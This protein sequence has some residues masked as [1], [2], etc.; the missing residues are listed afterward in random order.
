MLKR[1]QHDWEALLY[2]C[3]YSPADI[4]VVPF[5][6][7]AEFISASNNTVNKCSCISKM[8]RYYINPNLKSLIGYPK[9][10]S[11]RSS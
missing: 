1:V 9:F 10:L 8:I 4:S 11:S 7:G 5:L 6:C 3:N 2:N